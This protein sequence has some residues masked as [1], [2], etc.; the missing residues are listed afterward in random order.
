M[1]VNIQKFRSNISTAAI[2][3]GFL[4]SH[5]IFIVSCLIVKLL[6]IFCL[7]FQGAGS[8]LY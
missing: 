3:V 8:T 5:L 2:F 7:N 1:A 6:R 4:P